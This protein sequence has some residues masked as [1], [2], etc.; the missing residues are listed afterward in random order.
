MIESLK[1]NKI[2]TSVFVVVTVL[3]LWSTLSGGGSVKSSSLLTSTAQSP[4]A[5]VDQDIIR[6]LL[7]MQSIKLDGSVFTTP[8]FVLLRDFGR[9]IIPEP[10]GRQNPFAPVTEP[11]SLDTSAVD[12]NFFNQ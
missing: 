2:L 8:A 5:Q 6:L 10:V 11:S 4:R 9:D 3:F 7:D 12:Q 1:K